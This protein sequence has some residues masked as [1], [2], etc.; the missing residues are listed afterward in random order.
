MERTNAIRKPRLLASAVHGMGATALYLLGSTPCNEPQ[1]SSDLDLFIAYN[2]ARRFS[3]L[4]LAG[5][6]Q[7]LKQELPVEVDVTTRS[8]IHPMLRSDIEQFTVQLF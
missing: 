3:L 6:K 2:S 4:D 7:F 5:I 1:T 8:S